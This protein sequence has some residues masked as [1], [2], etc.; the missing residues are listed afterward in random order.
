MDI[1][2]E[3]VDAVHHKR[4][5]EA[6]DLLLGAYEQL[7]AGGPDSGKRHFMTMF[8][9]SI[10][11]PEYPPARAAFV[12]LRDKQVALLLQ[13]NEVFG[14][15][16]AGRLSESRFA[17]ICDMNRTLGEGAATYRLFAQLVQSAPARAAREAFLALPSVVEAGDFALAERYLDNPLV[18]LDQL[19]Q[20]ARALPLSPPRR[21]AP[22]VL[23]DLSN[24]LRD[25]KL[26]K[27]V[28]HGLGRAEEAHALQ[29]TVLN[30][31]ATDE[32]RELASRELAR[33]EFDTDL[34]ASWVAHSGPAEA[35]TVMSVSPH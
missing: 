21:E 11:V 34:F 25:V 27:A 30:G 23:A 3:I 4:H 19:N 10:L 1:I 7:A 29:H 9:W 28:L 2:A 16:C 32:I 17:H 8:Q 26:K 15:A 33:P 31:L 13:G 5:A 35:S 22:R 20:V 24:F 12:G 18:R 14:E 6:L